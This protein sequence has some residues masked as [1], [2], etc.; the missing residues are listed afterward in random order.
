MTAAANDASWFGEARKNARWLM[1][2]GIVQIVAGFLAIGSP[3]IAGITV[4]LVVGGVLAVSGV[5]RLIE[6]FKAGWFGAGVWGFLS[7]AFA[8]VVGGYMVFRPGVGLTSL[9]LLLAMYLVI[10]GIERVVIGFK[11]KPV[12]G[13]R[14]TMFGGFAG[15]VLG[16]L[17]WRQW[18]LSGTW[19]IGTLVGVH[20]LFAGWSTLAIGTAARRMA[21]EA[22]EAAPA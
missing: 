15:I 9:T 8:V 18:P 17:I 22:S 16:F 2:L 10:Y 3:L 11:I 7:G 20:L 14:A 6:A 21:K 12:P 5:A 4:T 13:W 19:A 1:V